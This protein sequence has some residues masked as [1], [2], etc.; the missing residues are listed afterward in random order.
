MNRDVL[1]FAAF[2]A[3]AVLMGAHPER[4]RHENQQQP[5]DDK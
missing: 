2:A 5:G 4:A 3:A 1:A